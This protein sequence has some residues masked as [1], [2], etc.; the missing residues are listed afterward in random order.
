MTFHRLDDAHTRVTLQMDFD[1]QGFV[2]NAGDKLGIVDRRVKGDLRPVQ[3]VHRG[4]RRLE[5]G[6]WRGQ[7]DRPGQHTAN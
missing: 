5:T 3:G 6:A 7:V 2:E 4:P 1:P